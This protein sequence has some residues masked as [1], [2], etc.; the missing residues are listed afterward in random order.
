MPELN[1]PDNPV[2]SDHFAQ[3]L[4]YAV[5]AMVKD[6]GGSIND[7]ELLA[8]MGL[9]FLVAAVPDEPDLGKWMLYA[10][11]AF[12]IPATRLFGLTIREVHPPEVALG[13][14]RAEGFGQHFDASYRPFILRALENN[15][16]V[17]A[18]QGWSGGASLAWGIITEACESGVGFSGR[19]FMAEGQPRDLVLETPPVQLYVVETIK[20]VNPS[21]MELYA[22][23]FAHADS[24]RRKALTDRFSV[25]TDYK[26]F[27]AWNERSVALNDAMPDE[28]TPDGKTPD[29]ETPA[30]KTPD[31][32]KPIDV[33]T[34]TSHEQLADSIR[35][36][37]Q[38]ALRF[39]E[40]LMTCLP[41][42]ALIEPIM[43]GTREIITAMDAILT[44]RDENKRG[45]QPVQKDFLSTNILAARMS[46]DKLAEAMKLMAMAFS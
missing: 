16:P 1:Q 11:D 3:S 28:E 15:Q 21:A 23:A 4:P 39:L 43:Q 27:D 7:D 2:A 20:P 35:A 24:E 37:H 31:D 45:L 41:D 32:K 14:G 13:L 42:K 5:S 36:H 46:A 19:V 30:P 10:R 34:M 18:W 38:S 25:V 6:S 17:F 33:E 29:E 40:P 8:A 22:I 12:L 26:A 44:H 9:S